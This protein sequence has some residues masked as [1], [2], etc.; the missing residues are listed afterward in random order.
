MSKVEGLFQ[1]DYPISLHYRIWE[2]EGEKKA[3]IMIFHGYGE[4]GDRYKNVVDVLRPSGF[5]IYAHDHRGHGTSQGLRTHVDEFSHYVDDA[6]SFYEQVVKEHVGGLP[7]FIL[8]HSMGSVIAMHYMQNYGEEV[9]GCVLSGA[10]AR[11]PMDSPLYK[12]GLSILGKV[13]PRQR[14]KFPLPAHFI[15]RDT[16]VVQAYKEDPLVCND[17]TLGLALQMSRGLKQGVQGVQ[18]ITKPVLIQYGSEDESFL[19]PE[20]LGELWGSSDATVKIYPGCRH[21]VYNEVLE[22]RNKVLK[23]LQDWLEEQI[24]KG[25]E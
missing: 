19:D 13:V 10:G 2:G 15:S 18:G 22:D 17:L 7:L 16:S 4:H 14:I 3:G 5:T 20:G 24:Y 1:G 25:E 6:Y 8:G 11:S 23:D 9:K 21:E 12:V